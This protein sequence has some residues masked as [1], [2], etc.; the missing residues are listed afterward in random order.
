MCLQDISDAHLCD[1]PL[2]SPCYNLTDGVCNG[3]D[4]KAMHFIKGQMHDLVRTLETYAEM[5]DKLSVCCE[6]RGRN[7]GCGFKGGLSGGA[8]PQCGGML[9]STAA[10]ETAATLVKKWSDETC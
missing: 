4:D 3:H 7:D 2:C 5:L 6:G 10:N 1:A 9:L 8:C